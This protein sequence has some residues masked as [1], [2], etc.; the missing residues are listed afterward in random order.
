MSLALMHEDRKVASMLTDDKRS[1]AKIRSKTNKPHRRHMT[2]HMTSYHPVPNMAIDILLERLS[3]ETTSPK[4]NVFLH[5]NQQETQ[6]V[7]K[8]NKYHWVRTLWC[9]LYFKSETQNG[10]ATASFARKRVT[11]CHER[12]SQAAAQITWGL[13]S[14]KRQSR[15]FFPEVQ[16]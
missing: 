16:H 6:E 7:K 10:N 3:K 4:T 8:V 11:M 13:T 2:R 12:H 14:G 15:A 5:N 1:C 9:G